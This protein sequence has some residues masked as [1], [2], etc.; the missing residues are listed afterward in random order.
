MKLL[1]DE[2]VMTTEFDDKGLVVDNNLF[3]YDKMYRAR[4][5]KEDF[6]GQALISLC[7]NETE[8]FQLCNE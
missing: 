4:V 2:Q 1:K 7:F 3:W 5:E 6:W 8:T